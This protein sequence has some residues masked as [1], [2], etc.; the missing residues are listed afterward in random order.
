M[1]NI[2][3]GQIKA[4][5]TIASKIFPGDEEY[6]AWLYQ[7]YEV[8]STKD[9]SFHQ[10]NDALDALNKELNPN[11]KPQ[12]RYYGSGRKAANRRTNNHLHKS[13]A[14]K[15]GALEK[16]LSWD[17]D[18]TRLLGFITRQTG[19]NKAVQMLTPGEATKVIVGMQRIAANGDK[20]IYKML[21]E[22]K[23]GEILTLNQRSS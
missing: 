10:A 6:R 22:M 7:R 1:P 23:P 20:G 19:H 16:L 11:R 18:K 17:N 2:N 21:N 3:K 8:E 5:R 14:E 4:L 9:I 13:Q 15:I 12:K